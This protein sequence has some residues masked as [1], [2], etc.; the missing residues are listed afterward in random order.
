MSGIRFS[1]S[2]SFSCPEFIF[3]SKKNGL[4]LNRFGVVVSKKVDKRAV[5]R[6]KIKRI[7]RNTLFNLNGN[8]ILGH[9]ILF[10]VRLGA[11]NKRGAEI[12]LVIKNAI[13]KAG[14]IK[15]RG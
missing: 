12:K 6:N 5:I 7:F 15:T 3:K 10:I 9:D 11:L 1:N 2:Y 4:T 14:L 13:E 8:M